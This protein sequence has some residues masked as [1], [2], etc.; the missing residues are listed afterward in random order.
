MGIPKE[1]Y[2]CVKPAKQAIADKKQSE[3][4]M[5]LSSTGV[6]NKR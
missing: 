4:V 5:I 3:N 1:A 2:R 6:G